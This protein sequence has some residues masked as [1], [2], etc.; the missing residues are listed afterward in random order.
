L[1]AI[2]QELSSSLDLG[3][4]TPIIFANLRRI[5]NYDY[6]VLALLEAEGRSLRMHAVDP[7]PSCEPLVA[8]GRTIPLEQAISA[9]AIATRNITYLSQEDLDRMNTALAN[10]IRGA[11]VQSICCVP[12]FSGNQALGTLS[13]GSQRENAFR[14]QDAEYLL[15]V[16]S[17]LAAAIHNAR[18][19][20]EIDQLKD[21]LAQ[22]K[23]YLE[24][25]IRSE[26]RI[27]EI[28]GNSSALKRV[29]EHAAIVGDTDSTV[30]ITGETG[31]GKEQVARAI[32]SMSRR[33]DRN[34]IKLNCA[35]IPTG[36]LESEL[37]G[38]EKGAF[39]G[40]VSPKVGRL[41]L[42]D[43]GTLFL[44]EVEDIPL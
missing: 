25:E 37:F 21:R 28:V 43:K 10:K 38:H 7:L 15:Q 23:R 1:V 41:E 36:L 27:D 34:F 39:T 2:S 30:L 4:L 19:Y 42:A 12:L 20:R 6:A 35:A 32:H 11:G 33:K 31:T 9:Q 3:H 26:L 24:N 40:A 14:P 8:E 44:D 5:T 13:C 16:A 17:Q 22:E 18:A 29:L